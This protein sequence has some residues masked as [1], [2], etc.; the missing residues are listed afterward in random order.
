VDDE[1]REAVIESAKT[2]F[3]KDVDIEKRASAMQV[4]ELVPAGDLR[5]QLAV[6]LETDERQERGD[7]PRHHWTVFF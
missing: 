5:E 2:E 7:R 4:D 6:R 1:S 3:E